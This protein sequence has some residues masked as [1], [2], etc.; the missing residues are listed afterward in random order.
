MLCGHILFDRELLGMLLLLLL[1]LLLSLELMKSFSDSLL[2][3][4]RV[5]SDIRLYQ[6]LLLTA[7]PF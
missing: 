7:I 4:N 5:R 3:V 2:H 1:L 6:T